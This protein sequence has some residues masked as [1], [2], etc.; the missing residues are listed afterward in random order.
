MRNNPFSPDFGSTS[1]LF[2]PRYSEINTIVNTFCSEIPS[3]HIFMIMGARESG[4]IGRGWDQGYGI[5]VG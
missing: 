5:K 4:K 2:I 1:N 3:S